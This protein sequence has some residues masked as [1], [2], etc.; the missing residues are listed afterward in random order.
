MARTLLD[1]FKNEPFPS[2]G[3][4]PAEEVYK[5]RDS[6]NILWSSANPLIQ[7]TGIQVANK[8]RSR[9]GNRTSETLVEQE[10]T[11]LRVLRTASIPVLYGTELGRLTLGSTRTKDRMLEGSAGAQSDFG[12]LGEKV[13]RVKDGIN[14][15]KSK[16]GFP[17]KAIP[18]YVVQQLEGPDYDLDLTQDRDKQLR[19]IRDD[20]E[21]G[22]LGNFLNKS[23]AEGRPTD[24]GRNLIGGAIREAKGQISKILFGNETRY[25][26]GV[27]DN[28]LTGRDLQAFTRESAGYYGVVGIN[29]GAET[30][31]IGQQT[32]DSD[33]SLV[34]NRT[35]DKKGVSYSSTIDRTGEPSERNDLSDKQ[36]L[37]GFPDNLREIRYSTPS[38]NVQRK[39][40][41]SDNIESRD[42]NSDEFLT[43][44]R[45]R[46][47]QNHFD[48]V[49]ISEVYDEENE[50][51]EDIDFITLKFKSI[52]TGKIAYFRSTISGLSE[53]FSPEWESNKFVGNPFSYYTYSG[54]ER[55][56]SF[57]FTVFSLS[58]REHK[59]SWQRLNF[60]SSLTYPQG[61]YE[62]S[63]AIKPPLIEF[64]LGDMYKRK[65]S[66]I[67]SLSFSVDDNYPWNINRD[68]SYVSNVLPSGERIV[69]DE[70]LT[71]YKLPMLIDV[72]IEIQILES[73]GNT[74]SKKFYSFNPQN[75]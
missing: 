73:R 36:V 64:T 53:T 43:S 37:G 11:G 6:K 24:I 22:I 16:L 33:T 8:A 13:E 27:E 65:A 30:N 26:V 9:L 10:T 25:R 21:G 62:N 32:P 42:I 7:N 54:I 29:Y 48:G 59:R 18:T 44:P 61:Y 34:I 49:N 2:Q 19:N 74:E 17:N 58:A 63:T 66:F 69:S 35:L 50:A 46:G 57:N 67:Q 71:N 40:K 39:S 70:D 55:S 52:P 28:E 51:L 47:I 12:L 5:I 1:L 38:N 75:V 20:A 23:L 56:V 15:L 45:G 14:S 68:E 4:R 3:G 60:L 31:P 72:D 41:F